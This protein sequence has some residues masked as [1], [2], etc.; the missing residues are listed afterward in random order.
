MNRWFQV[1]LVFLILV[2]L[3]MPENITQ[4]K[5][6][7]FDCS[8]VAEI[9]QRECL[10]LVALYTNTNGDAWNNKT[11][12]LVTTT[13]SNWFGITVTD[14]H[15]T[16]IDLGSFNNLN[17]S[18]P[19]EI[20][21]IPNL[22]TL[23]VHWANGLHGEIPPQIGNL[24]NLIR[25]EISNTTLGGE[26]PS[27]IGGL[28]N[29]QVLSLPSNQLSGSIPPEIGNLTALTTLVL[30]Y[31]QLSGTLPVQIGDLVNLRDLQLQYNRLTG[32]LPSTLGQLINLFQFLAEYNYFSGPIPA[33]IGSLNQLKY[34]NLRM[35]QFSSIPTNFTNLVNLCSPFLIGCFDYGLDLS[36]NALPVPAETQ[37]LATFLDSKDPDWQQTQWT[38]FN[39]CNEVSQIPTIECNALVDLYN[40]SNVDWDPHHLWLL[41]AQPDLWSGVF[42]FDGHVTGLENPFT[43]NTPL[44]AS[45]HNLSYL[46]V[47]DLSYNNLSGEISPEISQ[48]TQLTRLELDHNQLTG[49][50]P[51]S[52]GNLVNLQD[53]RLDDNKLS[54]FLPSE[55]TSLANLRDISLGGNQLTGAIPGWLENLSDL[56]R[57]NLSENQFTGGIPEQLGNLNKLK[58]L[59]LG[60]NQL[61][62]SIP[63]WLGDMSTLLSLGLNDNQFVGTIPP[64]LGSLNQL[65]SLSVS[66]NQLSG[67]I[68]TT[69]SSDNIWY[70]DFSDNQLEGSIPLNLSEI[71]FLNSLDLSNNQISGSIPSQ[72]GSLTKLNILDL[73]RNQLSGSIPSELGQLTN[74]SAL[75]LSGNQ[76]EGAIPSQIGN[77]ENLY[78]LDLSQNRLSGAAPSSLT[79]LTN[80][81]VPAVNACHSYGLNLGYN[82][83]TVP[84]APEDLAAFLILKD[85]DWHLTQAISIELGGTG[86]QLISRQGDVEL[87]F[88]SGS[89]PIGTT[90]TYIPLAS[91]SHEFDSGL[92]YGDLT[93]ALE[94]SVAKVISYS[95]TEPVTITLTY[96]EDTI[97]PRLDDLGRIYSI[98][99]DTL[100]LYFWD[101]M[102]AIWTDATQ[103]CIEPLPIIRNPDSNTI[104]LEVCKTGEFTL[105]G[106]KQQ[107]LI[108]LPMIRR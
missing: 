31:N 87:L 60:N 10:A 13:P 105:F 44:P 15:V 38:P 106:E 25:L 71:Y 52:L 37:E 27:T 89:A 78:E 101:E 63:A 36:Y 94:A 97:N 57:L 1:L 39:S 9:P 56:E 8:S 90:M 65:T 104:S 2:S 22:Q 67:T 41:A 79:S 28:V 108:F 5:A 51:A 76:L 64:E 3:M 58:Y 35:N 80:L 69:I 26:L 92:A 21:D 95:F 55:L 7:L 59:V 19:P 73:S 77:L 75:F 61:S 53:L 84:A 72:L 12:W 4:A 88:P 100:N 99:E 50:I 49:A 68:P 29:L 91:P 47:L 85:P 34:L 86:D 18:F 6:E 20:G 23:R 48:L 66:N 30:D 98:P 32:N 16:T 96:S 43:I 107:T 102:Q 14:G 24:T 62:G 83:L 40:A 74:L 42:V 11:N 54:G 103:T 33:E 82:R 45:F 17:G 46:T 93:F 81:C 70:L